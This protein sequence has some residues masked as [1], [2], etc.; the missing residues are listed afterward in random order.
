MALIMIAAEGFHFFPRQLLF[1]KKLH[2]IL[3]SQVA[4]RNIITNLVQVYNPLAP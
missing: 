4:H 1:I 2:I 3:E